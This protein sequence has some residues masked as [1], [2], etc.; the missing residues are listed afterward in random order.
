MCSRVRVRVC[1]RDEKR[2][3]L[4]AT[5]VIDEDFR[6]WFPAASRQPA[7]STSR[8]STALMAE[9][10]IDGDPVAAKGLTGIWSSRRVE[11]LSG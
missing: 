3:V 4:T 6:V 5:L 7:R 2:Y 8:Q 10:V 11:G 9:T 1:Q